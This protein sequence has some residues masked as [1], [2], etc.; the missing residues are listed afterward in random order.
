MQWDLTK[1]KKTESLC[2]VEETTGDLR[3]LICDPKSVFDYPNA[4]LNK[5]V[6]LSGRSGFKAPSFHKFH[7]AFGI[8]NRECSAKPK[9]FSEKVLHQ[10][11]NFEKALKNHEWLTGN[12]TT[13]SPVVW[14]LASRRLLFWFL[15]P[16]NLIVCVMSSI[17]RMASVFVQIIFIQ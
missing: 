6:V 8:P 5:V 1:L 13:N 7:R 15:P 10:C 16:K 3:D 9:N 4:A 12:S 2:Y 14:F 17:L 11:H